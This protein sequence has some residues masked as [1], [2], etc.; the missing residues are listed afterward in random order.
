MTL[1]ALITAISAQD[2]SKR[3]SLRARLEKDIATAKR[4]HGE[5]I[6]GVTLSDAA[7]IRPERFMAELEEQLTDTHIVVADASFSSI[8]V[9]NFLTAKAER[10][11]ITPRGRRAWGGD[12]RWLWVQRSEIPPKPYAASWVMAALDTFGRNWK[13]RT[14]TAFR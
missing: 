2:L 13:L 3:Q 9:A 8:W 10:R 5:E 11:F 12:F 4:C 1:R 7:P 14:A 6:I